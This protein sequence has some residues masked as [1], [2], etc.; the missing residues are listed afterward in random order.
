M[1]KKFLCVVTAVTLV[2]GLL[3]GCGSKNNHT[4][5]ELKSGLTSTEINVVS[6][7]TSADCNL[8]LKFANV[9]TDFPE[10]QSRAAELFGFEL[11]DNVVV[12]YHTTSNL[13]SNVKGDYEHNIVNNTGSFTS[14]IPSVN[15]IYNDE[16]GTCSLNN[17]YEMYMDPEYS[18][19][20]PEKDGSWYY[21]SKAVLGENTGDSSI[22]TYNVLASNLLSFFNSLALK[23]YADCFSV[24]EANNVITVTAD[25]TFDSAMYKLL[26]EEDLTFLSNTLDSTTI[27][28]S[29][30]LLLTTFDIF[31]DSY[32]MKVPIHVV[33]EFDNISNKVV[34]AYRI[35]R[36]SGNIKSDLVANYTH[37]ELLELFKGSTFEDFSNYTFDLD[38]KFNNNIVFDV[39]CD[40]NPID[41]VVPEDV[42]TKAVDLTEYAETIA[43]ANASEDEGEEHSL[44]DYSGLNEEWPVFYNDSTTPLYTLFDGSNS[45]VYSFVVPEDFD[46][47]KSEAN[48]YN[49]VF[50]NED[51]TV[52]VTYEIPEEVYVCMFDEYPDDYK[53]FL[54]QYTEVGAINPTSMDGYTDEQKDMYKF[55]IFH[56]KAS[57]Y[58]AVMYFDET[59]SMVVKMHNGS[60]NVFGSYDDVVDFINECF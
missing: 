12:D 49:L 25:I 1:K 26:D 23:G 22:S 10:L 24:S 60:N 14:N 55:R 39:T 21:A 58:V 13:S 2:G 57:D 50:D 30:G 43:E 37:D 8:D 31:G 38:M 19:F 41:V 45:Q 15:A 40:Y 3:T 18:Y 54:G 32:E 27:G 16:D 5:T 29:L 44:Y 11:E 6:G 28:G 53:E 51:S 56:D 42:K 59:S 20:L 9:G 17:Y 47:N 52:S 34:S 7:N 36:I 46:V 48:E 4:L 35:K 33:M